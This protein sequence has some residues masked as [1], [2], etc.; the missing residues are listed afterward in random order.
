VSVRAHTIVKNL[1]T[2][3]LT[4]CS[5]EIGVTR[6][7]GWQ[8]PRVV[9][10][11][12]AP[13][14]KRRRR[15]IGKS[16]T[17]VGLDVRDPQGLTAD[18]IALET[19]TDSFLHGVVSRLEHNHSAR[20]QR[21][22]SPAIPSVLRRAEAFIHA[23][24]DRPVTL[25]DVAAAAGCGT[26]TLNATF[27]RFR[28]MTPLAALHDIRLQHVRDALRMAG[29]KVAT[30]TIARRFGF[31]NPSRF[32][33]AYVKRFGEHRTRQGDQSEYYDEPR[34]T[35]NSCPDHGVQLAT[36]GNLRKGTAAELGGGG[37]VP[38]LGVRPPRVDGPASSGTISQYQRYGA[39]PSRRGPP[40]VLR[41][42]Q[43]NKAS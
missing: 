21:Q 42:S 27:R 38:S 36:R 11:G 2:P 13:C 43:Q 19:F 40:P 12:S 8:V 33:A 26:G 39:C 10:G 4:T 1:D 30:R 16:T 5:P 34:S 7:T 41:Q 9:P 28:D 25:A 29:D 14:V 32:I 24:A 18:P 20:M 6:L 15:V 37:L 31:T 22:G 17:Y 35:A 23:H 3:N